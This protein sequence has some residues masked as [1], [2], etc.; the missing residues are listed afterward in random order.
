[1]TDIA[2]AIAQTIAGLGNLANLTLIKMQYFIALTVY[3]AQVSR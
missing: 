2:R 3:Q 1:M